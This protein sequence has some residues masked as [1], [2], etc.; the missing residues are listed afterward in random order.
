MK[1]L[2]FAAI[3]V[4]LSLLP[5]VLGQ[6]FNRGFGRMDPYGGGPLGGGEIVVNPDIKTARAVETRTGDMPLWTNP[7]AFSRDVFTFARIRYDKRPNGPW[8][9]RT[10]GWSTDLPDSDINLSFRLQQMTSLRVDTEGRLIRLTDPELPN[11]P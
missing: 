6:G 9:P 5:M 2:R 11:Y 4:L 8:L 3:V 1:F 10:G 7:P